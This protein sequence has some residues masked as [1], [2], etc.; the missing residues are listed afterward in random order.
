[1]VLRPSCRNNVLSRVFKIFDCPQRNNTST[2][3]RGRHRC[4]F[5][6]DGALEC[7]SNCTML[8]MSVVD[9]EPALAR[10]SIECTAPQARPLRLPLSFFRV[11]LRGTAENMDDRRVTQVSSA[12]RR[13]PRGY[14]RHKPAPMTRPPPPHHPRVTIEWVASSRAKARPVQKSPDA[15]RACNSF[16]VDADRLFSSQTRYHPT[17]L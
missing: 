8:G 1:M 4:E 10:A 3:T 16:R 15:E 13:F 9:A 6:A 11:P 14:D 2:G 7:G 17:N 5:G 12:R